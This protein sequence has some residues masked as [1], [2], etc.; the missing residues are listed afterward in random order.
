MNPEQTFFTNPELDGAFGVIMALATEVYVLKDR[1]RAL[2]AQL[3]SR[4]L[5]DLAELASEP[6]A[7]Q[8]AASAAER[9]AFVA[10]LLQNLLGRQQARGA[11]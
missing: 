11:P 10:H 6:D 5:V 4:G 3:A 1:M 7:T 2:E 9:D 8:L